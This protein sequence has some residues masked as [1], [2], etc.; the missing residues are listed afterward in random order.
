MSMP[1]SI[2]AANTICKSV[3]RTRIVAFAV[4]EVVD[5]IVACAA[6]GIAGYVT[7]E[8]SRDELVDTVIGVARG[9]TMLSPPLAAAL[10]GHVV[11]ATSCGDNREVRSRLTVRELEIVELIDVPSRK[12]L[13]GLREVK[14]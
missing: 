6:A 3:P 12:P 4:P 9:D 1:E 5:E 11:S 8:A 10:L 2:Q 7:R 14:V 13:Q